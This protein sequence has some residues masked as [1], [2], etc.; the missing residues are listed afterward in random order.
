M[1]VLVEA[2]SVIIRADSLLSKFPGGWGAFQEILP[3]ETMCADNEVVRV[4]FMAPHDVENFIETL[5]LN[6]LVFLLNGEAIDVVV[7]D[8]MRG[9][10][11]K[12]EWLEFGHV[13]L[14]GREQRVAVCRL[15]DSQINQVVTPPIWKFEG[16][17]SE[18]YE[19]VPTE[20]IEKEMK[21]LRRENWVDVYLNP[22]TGQEM[23]VGRTK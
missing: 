6:G 18:T 5:E 3:N 19:F 2:T 17:L 13:N 9:L 14:G 7:A 16:S 21:L 15:K 12:C 4:G 11:S 8:Q 22:I 1:A 23:Y 10:T 20:H